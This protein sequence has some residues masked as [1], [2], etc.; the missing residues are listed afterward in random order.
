MGRG[1]GEGGG[2]VGIMLWWSSCC[3]EQTSQV[4]VPPRC[5]VSVAS[6]I[7][8]APPEIFLLRIIAISR[9]LTKLCRHGLLLVLSSRQ[10]ISIGQQHHL[11]GWILDIM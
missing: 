9:Q 8:L 1:G 10:Q 5:V 2:G 3:Q 4:V 7:V 11:L 6:C